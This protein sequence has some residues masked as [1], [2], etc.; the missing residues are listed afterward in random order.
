M[1]FAGSAAGEYFDL[2]AEQAA[3][4][5][6]AAHLL[7]RGF[8]S[9][10]AAQLVALADRLLAA[11]Y[12]APSGTAGGLL[13]GRPLT[14]VLTASLRGSA[15]ASAGHNGL[16]EDESGSE[17]HALGGALQEVRPVLV[18]ALRRP[19]DVSSPSGP[20]QSPQHTQHGYAP[21]SRVC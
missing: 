19:D 20:A 17:E 15:K 18:R 4:E 1:S 13:S 10:I 14:A 7:R 3:A 12:A 11:Q 21:V 6:V 2:L 5:G 9:H 8:V 16:R